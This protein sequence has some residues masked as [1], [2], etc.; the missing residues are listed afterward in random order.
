LAMA[1]P[2]PATR[3]RLLFRHPEELFKDPLEKLMWNP[4]ACV[5]Y[6]KA[7]HLFVHLCR[8]RDPAPGYGIA[9][10]IGQSRSG[11][12]DSDISGKAAL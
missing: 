3:L 2:N 9:K 11:K 5:S 8:Y 4:T 7:D 12:L 1:S 6:M 10:G